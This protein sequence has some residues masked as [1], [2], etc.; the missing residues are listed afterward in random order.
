MPVSDFL[1]ILAVCAV[2]IFVCRVVP[3][4]AFKGRELPA[5]V[6]R[7]LNFIPAAAFAAL[8]ANDLF[9]PDR[10]SGAFAEWGAPLVAAVLVAAVGL[11]TRSMVWCIVVGVASLGLMQLALGAW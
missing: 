9:V 3:L 4:V 10:F 7:A 11:K 5:G 2:A 8:V 6:E 1:V